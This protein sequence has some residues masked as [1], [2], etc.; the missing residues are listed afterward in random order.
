MAE[1]DILSFEEELLF[2]LQLLV[3]DQVSPP[4]LLPTVPCL[5]FAPSSCATLSCYTRHHD[6]SPRRLR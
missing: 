5:L 3:E 4:P 6:L 2:E 1:S